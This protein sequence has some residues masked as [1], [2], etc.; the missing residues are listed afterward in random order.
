M[1]ASAHRLW[2]NSVRIIFPVI[3]VIASI[4]V[5]GLTP[6]AAATPPAPGNACLFNSPNGILAIGYVGHVGWAYRNGTA[7]NWTF[8]AT[9][10]NTQINSGL[11]IDGNAAATHSWIKSGTWAQVLAA[12]GLGS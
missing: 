6:A 3:L 5:G 11:H 9:E 4:V 8:G 2:R 12:F 1:G 10:G 7:N